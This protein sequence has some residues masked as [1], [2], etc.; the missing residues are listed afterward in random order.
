MIGLTLKKSQ[1]SMKKPSI[2]RKK[3]FGDSTK[4]TRIKLKSQS[5]S[6]VNK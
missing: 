5:F 4:N 1:V 2:I 6:T 3:K